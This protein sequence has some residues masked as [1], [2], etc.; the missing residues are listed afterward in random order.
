MSGSLGAGFFKGATVPTA[1]QTAQGNNTPLL[2]CIFATTSALPACTYNNGVGTLTANANGALPVIDGH[3]P[4]LEEICLI[5]DQ[6]S[7]LQNGLYVVTDLGS[8]STPFILTR[9]SAYD[10]T[11]EVYPS[12]INVQVGTVNANKYFL[13][14]TVDPVIGTDP[15]V[16]GSTPAPSQTTINQ[17]LLF[18]DVYTESALP[19]SPVYSSGPDASQ[20]GFQATLKAT[21][22]GEFPTLQGVTP[23]LFMKVLVKDQA[24]ARHNGDYILLSIPGYSTK[25]TLARVSYTAQAL[26]QTFWGIYKG[27][28]KGTLFQQT[29]SD[30]ATATLG[31]SGNIVFSNVTGGTGSIFIQKTNGI[32]VYYTLLEDARDYSL[33]GENIYV[34][35]G[36]YTVT[37]TATNGLAKDGVNWVFEAGAVVNKATAGDIFNTSGFSTSCNVFGFGTFSKTSTSGII[38]NNGFHTEN[39]SFNSS[40]KCVFRSRDL[41]ST[42]D[43]CLT[44]SNEI[45]AICGD[46]TST[47]DVAVWFARCKY[48]LDCKNISSTASNGMVISYSLGGC[49]NGISATSSTSIGCYVYGDNTSYELDN[50]NISLTNGITYGAYFSSVVAK[51]STVTRK[52]IGLSGGPC[53]VEFNGTCRTLE[54]LG[55][56]LCF[57]KGG[58]SN[59]VK[60]TGGNVDTSLQ[61]YLEN[62]TATI[63][64]SG[65]KVTIRSNE[66]ATVNGF[67]IIQTGGEIDLFGFF[68][69]GYESTISAGK[70]NFNNSKWIFIGSRLITISSTGIVNLGS[71]RIQCAA[72]DLGNSFGIGVYYTGGKLISNGAVIITPNADRA[73][74]IATVG[75]L[76]FKVLSGGFNTNRNENG[77]TLVAKKQKQLFTVNTPGTSPHSITL[78]DGSGPNELFS[79]TV[80]T[81][82]IAIAADLVSLINAS[83]TLDC[84]AIDNFDGTFYV[85]SDVAGVAFTPSSL[86][87]ITTANIPT[88]PNSFLITNSV[89]GTIIEN[90][91]VE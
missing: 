50:I 4:V 47:G 52:N 63:D 31:A 2:F 59:A 17:H 39:G 83:G 55:S 20:P 28:G 62:N 44:S 85:E 13:Q 80:T 57:V 88:R 41:T 38:F 90:A 49:V 61:N 24:D 19:N 73:P 45:D 66:Y 26:Y 60:C 91:N 87:R 69:T 46:I 8:G 78:N 3:T 54:S 79:S 77:G 30:L 7:A 75:S 36:T 29:T 74:I 86:V 53:F 67:R 14:N 6:A 34:Q 65:G 1:A 43:K 37:T 58:Y 27:T 23:K 89:T 51:I 9:L 12:Q 48:K 72:S 21:T 33:S 10:E 5:K 18:T 22:S 68:Y 25:W 35:T 40:I 15:L 71:S 64:V 70:L 76:D 56:E 32:R 84:T 42:T 11:A 81:S 16:F 82:N